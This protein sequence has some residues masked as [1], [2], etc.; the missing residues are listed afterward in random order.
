MWQPA[1]PCDVPS[2]GGGGG[3][4]RLRSPFRASPEKQQDYKDCRLGTRWHRHG[5]RATCGDSAL[6][7]EGRPFCSVQRSAGLRKAPRFREDGLL[8]PK[9]TDLN[10]SLTQKNVGPRNWAPR[11]PGQLTHEISHH[12]WGAE[13]Q[14]PGSWL[15]QPALGRSPLPCYFGVKHTRGFSGPRALRC[16]GETEHRQ[17]PP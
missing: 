4:K 2:V 12:R 3:Q 1:P 9:S 10:G 8:G 5:L 15:Q 13:S 17:R 16:A 11:G 7:G 6:S 14:A